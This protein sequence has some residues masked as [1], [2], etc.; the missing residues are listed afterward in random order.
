MSE[1]CVE[2]I[3]ITSVVADPACQP[4]TTMDPSIIDEYAEQMAGG[5][6]FPP[7]KAKCDG[8]TFYLY[9]GFHRFSA[10]KRTGRT[11]VDVEWQPGT[12]LDAIEAS[13]A[14]NAAHGLRRTNVDKNRAVETMFRV[15]D[16]REENW[17]DRE[18]AR[19]CG[20]HERSSIVPSVRA[21]LEG[22]SGALRQ[23]DPVRTVTRGG[24]TYAM[25]TSGRLRPAPGI[26]QD[27]PMFAVVDLE[28]GEIVE[29]DPEPPSRPRPAV[30]GD[31]P[32]SSIPPMRETSDEERVFDQLVRM[33]GVTARD[34]AAVAEAAFLYRDVVARIYLDRAE[35]VA[36]WHQR[37]VG[38]LR[39]R[40]DAPLRAVK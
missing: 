33:S 17:S 2:L 13:C 8:E 9:D 16:E 21:H 3:A 27:P 32:V 18:I 6:A 5:S 22:P 19:R 1:P 14:V 34:P 7:I 4:R 31:L 35:T 23:I 11:E 12:R 36:A 10:A 39:R 25:D 29:D 26:P 38:E 28:T 15:M 20:L 30:I 24:T 37:F 40:F